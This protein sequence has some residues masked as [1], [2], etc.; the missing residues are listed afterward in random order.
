MARDLSGGEAGRAGSSI[1]LLRKRLL[2]DSSVRGL[3]CSSSDATHPARLVLP[4]TTRKEVEKMRA[5]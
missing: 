2:L 5:T 1:R 4:F 3:G